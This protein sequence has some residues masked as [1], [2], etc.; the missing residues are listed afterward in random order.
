MDLD[1]PKP[2]ESDFHHEF[3]G[4]YLEDPISELALQK[5]PKHKIKDVF[6]PSHGGPLILMDEVKKESKINFTET[7]VENQI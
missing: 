1:E 7:I 3:S 5:K 4:N 2:S 6:D